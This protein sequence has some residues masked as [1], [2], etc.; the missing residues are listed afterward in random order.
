MRPGNKFRENIVLSTRGKQQKLRSGG[1]G[2]E[3]RNRIAK[4]KVAI[5]QMHPIIWNR[6]TTREVKRKLYKTIVEGIAICGSEVWEITKRN[7]NSA[8]DV[9][10]WC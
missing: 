3:K 4:G 5:R 9:D 1:S 10:F 8:M 2:K 6:N 7:E